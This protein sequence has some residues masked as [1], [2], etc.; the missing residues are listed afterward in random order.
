MQA[1]NTLGTAEVPPSP[2]ATPESAIHLEVAIYQHSLGVDREIN[3]IADPA[4]NQNRHI[5]VV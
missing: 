1:L 4:N 2:G 5:S 3:T